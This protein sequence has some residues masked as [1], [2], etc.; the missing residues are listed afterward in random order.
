M[1]Q[2]LLILLMLVRATVPHLLK[3]LV[4][5]HLLFNLLSLVMVSELQLLKDFLLH[6]MSLVRDSVVNPL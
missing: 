4:I 2:L 6:L 5:Q 1:E 3:Y